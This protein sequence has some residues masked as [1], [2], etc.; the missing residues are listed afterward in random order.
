MTIEVFAYKARGTDGKTSTGVLKA[1]SESDAVNELHQG[2]MTVIS[3]DREAGGHT[4]AGGGSSIPF[5]G[6]FSGSRKVSPQ[7]ARVKDAEM[8]VFTR[9]LATMV[10]SGIPLVDGLEILAEQIENA[11]FRAVIEAVC[12]EV[13]GGKDLSSALKLFPRIFP[14]IYVNMI[15]AG[16]ASGQ[17]DT[18][19]DRLAE[20]QE[21][22]LLM[23]FGITFF[24]LVFVIPKFEDMFS[25]LNV[26]LPGITTALLS[27][28]LFLRENMLYW[29]GAAVALGVALT[30]WLRSDGGITAR[31]WV[32][33]KIPVFG[34]LFKKVTLSRFSRTL[35][36][37]IQSGV[38]ILGALEIV[39]QTCGNRIF[40]RAVEEASESVR[41]GETLGEPLARSGV[42]PPMVTRM[43][44]IGERTGA[45][46]GLLEKIA[47]FY[48][49]QVK[50]SVEGLTS[51]IE[52]FMIGIM[53]FLVGGMVMAIFLP[54]FK[55]VG[56]MGG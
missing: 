40:A 15:C 43:V 21:A 35:S 53:G 20:Y 50:T 22:S 52:P 42:F 33:I 6:L 36:T 49:R 14:D 30:Y 41:Q 37:L 48:D 8:V 26:E 19:L 55:M 16:E 1:E 29:G 24:L 2:G 54:I 47:D 32:L 23:V 44:A 11:G 5:S 25:T 46:E 45:L 31:D 3:L 9:Q 27:A 34:P 17:L 12:E 10:G 13:R 51:M 38:P 28:S 7:K 18:V 56:S 39:S 4:D